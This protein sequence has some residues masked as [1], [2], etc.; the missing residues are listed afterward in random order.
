MPLHDWTRVD[1]GVFHDFHS[2]WIAELRNA[3]NR[4]LLPEGYYAMSE[5][6]VGKYLADVIALERPTANG[7]HE[8]SGGLALATAPPK[9]G[10]Q[11]ALSPAAGTR[12]KSLAIRHVSGHRLV[13]LLEIVS[14]ANKDRKKHLGDLLNKLEDA[15]SHGIHLLLLDL[16]PPGRYDLKGIHGALWNRLGDKADSPPR[17]KPLTLSSYV[18]DTTTTAFVEYTAVGREL[19]AMPL[20]V[21]PDV[22]INVPLQATYDEAWSGTPAWWREVLE[23]ADATKPP[24]RR[25]RDT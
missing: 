2:V 9:V 4:G 15:L 12:R 7:T 8:I 19:T 1:A 11:I 6:H 23:A 10:K 24:R 17:E 5:Q 25:K 14:P 13:A 21:D 18:A 16:I 22:Y 3:C 20:F